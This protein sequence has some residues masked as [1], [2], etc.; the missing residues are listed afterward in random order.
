VFSRLA[1]G[2]MG[3]YGAALAPLSPSDAAALF[4]LSIAAALSLLAFIGLR[5]PLSSSE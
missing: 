2:L 1:I 3:R 4:K 5:F